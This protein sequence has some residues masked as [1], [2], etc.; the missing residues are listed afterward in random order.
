M[1]NNNALLNRNIGRDLESEYDYV[2]K[3]Q[4]QKLL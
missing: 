2:A 1:N 3:F 4:F